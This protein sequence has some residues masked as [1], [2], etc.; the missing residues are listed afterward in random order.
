[1][2]GA[3]SN[4]IPPARSC[5]SISGSPP[6]W[7]LG[8]TVT[9]NRP[10][11]C[12]PIACAA[13]INRSVRGWVSG[14]LTPS[15]N[16]NSAAALAGLLRML[17]A[18]VADADLSKSLRVIFIFL[19][20]EFLVSRARWFAPGQFPSNRHH[21]QGVWIRCALPCSSAA[22]PHRPATAM[23]DETI[24]GNPRNHHETNGE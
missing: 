19:S 16:S 2:L 12:A 8:K 13:S 11:D 15:L 22:A 17:V 9:F 1:M 7:L 10:D 21:P 14:V 24:L 6:S 5:D 18:Q 20:P 4:S 3:A 23:S